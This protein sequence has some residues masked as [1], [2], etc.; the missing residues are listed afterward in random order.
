MKKELSQKV[1]AT[2]VGDTTIIHRSLLMRL[3]LKSY[4]PE[5]KEYQLLLFCIHDHKF[6]INN[7]RGDF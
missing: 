7:K 1:K 3:N 4:K 2:I 5:H 6:D